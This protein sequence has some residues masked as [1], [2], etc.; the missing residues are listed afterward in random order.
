MPAKGVLTLYL[1]PEIVPELIEAGK[2]GAKVEFVLKPYED[3]VA[4]M[5]E[6]RA[7]V[8]REERPS[9]ALSTAA[10]DILA[11]ENLSKVA[12]GWRDAN[13]AMAAAL[14]GCEHKAAKLIWEA[15]AA[16][17]IEQESVRKAIRRLGTKK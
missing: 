6:F 7:T 14:I 8:D 11:E 1:P 3:P 2:R 9:I 17:G 13:W 12:R 16:H 15:G 5:A 10:A 4:V